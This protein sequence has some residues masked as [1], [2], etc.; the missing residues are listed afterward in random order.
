MMRAPWF[1]RDDT[2]AARAVTLGFAPLSALYD[3]AQR[4][5]W[6]MTAPKRAPVPVICI[7]NAT[8]GGVG[9][10]PFAIAL[11]EL[12]RGES[13]A[14]H[15]LTRG[16]GGAL[17]GPVKVDPSAHNFNDV[18]D[19][20]L[21]LARHGPVWISKDRPAGALAAAK[22][23]AG[24][25]IMDDGFQNPTIEKTVS[26]LLIDASE[27]GGN[28]KIFPAGPFREP[29]DRARARADIVVYVGGDEE[30]ASRAADENHSAFAAW[31]EPENAPENVPVNTPAPTP[32]TGRVV[33][34]SGIGNPEKFYTSL[35]AAGFV[36][37]RTA[38]FPD[39]HRFSDQD[40][41]ALARLA[42]SE[43]A[44]LIT[45]E[46][47]YVRLPEDFR[48]DVLTFP[49]AMKINQPSLLAATIR[50]TIDRQAAS[51]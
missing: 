10:T 39:H 34:F 51:D 35:K 18:G 38:S 48:A 5:R 6:R 8:L 40:L 11:G 32:E 45:T 20:A 2:L 22:D 49:I 3:A 19:E 23:G 17:G 47:D 36:I 44:P 12:L 9:K 42:A 37:T 31:P 41:A 33:A 7:G 26:I 29:L 25:I 16:Y 21:L 28:G 14:I 46:K 30:I 13:G 15:F 24:L 4:A 1:W 50:T 27:D 43:K